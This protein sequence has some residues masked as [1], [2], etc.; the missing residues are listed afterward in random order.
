MQDVPHQELPQWTSLDSCWRLV[1]DFH[2]ALGEPAPTRPVVLGADRLALRVE[3]MIGELREL[4]SSTTMVDQVDALCDL[5]YFALGSLVEM[6][7]PPG[8]P[9]SFVH[10][11]NMLKCDVLA[12]SRFDAAGRLKKPKDWIGPEERINDYIRS[13]SMV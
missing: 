3:W 9:F 8:E 2:E 12:M 7:I 11:A 6:G 5:I 10:D 4:R 13:L 1:R